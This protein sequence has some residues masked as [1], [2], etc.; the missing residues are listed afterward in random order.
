MAGLD[1]PSGI[2]LY[3]GGKCEVRNFVSNGDND[4]DDDD[5]DGDE[6]EDVKRGLR[7]S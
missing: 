2:I 6:F 4:D 1:G 5:D 3:R 7:D